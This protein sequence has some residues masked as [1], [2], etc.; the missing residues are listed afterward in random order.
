MYIDR[1]IQFLRFEKRYSHNTIIA[2]EKDLAQFQSY[3]ITEYNIN[4]IDQVN[5]HMI[6]SWLVSLSNEKIGN[7]SINRKLSTLKTYYKF[8]IREN[9]ISENPLFKIL[10]PKTSK[11]LPEFVR[12]ENMNQLLDD[13]DF[14]D[15]FQGIRDKLII[16]MF[17]FT[18]MR[19][20]ELVNLKDAD[21]N[22]SGRQIKVL[23]KRNKERIIPI[24]DLL[25]NSV[26]AYL[27]GRKNLVNFNEP[28]NYFFVTD[29]GKRIY[30]E[31]VYR[32][33]NSYL[34]MVSTL[35][36]KSP[37]ILRHTFATH[38]L[39][40][41]ADLNAIKELLGHSNLSATQV[42]THNTIEK[43]KSIYKLAHPRA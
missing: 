36:K 29:K 37:H 13:I 1:F 2:Y 41:G 32:C 16:E 21:I 10:S 17:Y 9:L 23:G 33:I 28:N 25:V 42:Y 3:L 31:L 12:E 38:M 7:R 43:L 35:R 14:G 6:R 15:G 27:S 40:N 20:S 11:R 19:L 5:Y 4:N 34:G 24:T 18:G 22:I 8:L 39:N 30:K 26:E